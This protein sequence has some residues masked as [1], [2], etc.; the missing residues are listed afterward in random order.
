SINKQTKTK[1]FFKKKTD[2]KNASPPSTNKRGLRTN[3]FQTP[4]IPHPPHII[5]SLNPSTI[6]QRDSQTLIISIDPLHPNPSLPTASTITTPTSE[7]SPTLNHSSEWLRADEIQPASDTTDSQTPFPATPGNLED[8]RAG[9]QA[10]TA[11]T[12]DILDNLDYWRCWVHSA[13]SGMHAV[14]DFFF[15]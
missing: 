10:S 14:A 9:L 1:A 5:M 12:D 2:N 15:V 6:R 4:S 8:G 13:T 7:S 3:V 11:G